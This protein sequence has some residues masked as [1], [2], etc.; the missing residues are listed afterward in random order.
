MGQLLVCRVLV[1]VCECGHVL[2]Y[3]ASVSSPLGSGLIG[4]GERAEGDTWW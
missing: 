3:S 2:R 4:G 1:M